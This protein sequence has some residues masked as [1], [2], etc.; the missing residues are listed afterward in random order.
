MRTERG[1]HSLQAHGV[2]HLQQSL[3]CVHRTAGGGVDAY[4]EPCRNFLETDTLHTEI[5]DF[6]EVVWQSLGV[7]LHKSEE[8]LLLYGLLEALSVVELGQRNVDGVGKI[9]RDG[10]TISRTGEIF[11]FIFDRFEQIALE[12]ASLF[13]LARPH[14]GK[15]RD[16]NIL[17]GILGLVDILNFSESHPLGDIV[18]AGIED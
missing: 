4:A 12:N 11:S 7:M 16:K 8:A 10:L 9:D 17:N 3:P 15:D 1:A 2:I 18:V 6:A 13:I 14:F 5:E